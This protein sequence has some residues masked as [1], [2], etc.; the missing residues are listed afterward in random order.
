[1]KI[2][3][4][5]N[6]VMM[7]ERFVGYL[8]REGHFGQSELMR[9]KTQMLQ[10]I[11]GY[12]NKVVVA[13]D[14]K[15]PRRYYCTWRDGQT[16]MTWIFQFIVLPQ[17]DLTVIYNLTYKRTVEMPNKTYNQIKESKEVKKILSLMEK[18]GMS[19][20]KKVG[21]YT[22]IDGRWW[23]GLLHGLEHKGLAQDVRMYDNDKYKGCENFETYVLF[24]RCDNRKY[25]YAKIV[26]V[27]GTKELKWQ[28][29]KKSEMPNIILD[30]LKTIN[31]LEHGPYILL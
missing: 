31:P 12:I 15:A 23:G 27:D 2:V 18:M 22:A 5:N 29:V 10:F 30:D 16:P 9:N 4:T 21:D 1:M 8:K 24:R 14:N 25:F 20:Q 26:P 6:I 3:V 7:A 13:N 11:R 17:Q 19:T 28:I